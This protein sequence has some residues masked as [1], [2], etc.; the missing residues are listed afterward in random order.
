NIN[1][2]KIS[3][4]GSFPWGVN[5]IPLSTAIS[6][7]NFSKYPIAVDN[8]GALIC[9]WDDNRVNPAIKVYGHKIQ[10]SGLT[11]FSNTSE[12]PEGFALGQNYPNPFNPSTRISFTI[13]EKSS[14]T[15]KVYNVA[16]CEVKTILNSEMQAGEHYVQFD[17]GSLSSGIYFY[18]LC[19]NGVSETRKMILVK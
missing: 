13:P 16:G 18:T 5:S 6:A 14:V 2:Q 1:V 9:V 17:A 10:A 15:L 8:S 19:A 3:S 12:S 4:F 7:K 11:G